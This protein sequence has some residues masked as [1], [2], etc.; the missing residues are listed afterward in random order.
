MMLG[1]R[2]DPLD[3]IVAM[4][5]GAPF[6]G[7]NRPYSFHRPTDVTWDPQGNIFVSD[8]YTDSRVVKYD[9]NGRFIKSAGARGNGVMQFSTPHGITADNQGNIYVADRGNRR[10]VVLDNDLNWKAAWENVGA[11]WGVCMSQS[12]PQYLY[13]SNP[14][15]TGRCPQGNHGRD[16]QDDA[17]RQDLGRFG[18]RRQG[19]R[20]VRERPHH[21]LPRPER[22]VHRGNQGWRVQKNTLSRARSP[23]ATRRHP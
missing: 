1:K 22:G 19:G 21:G 9:R 8:G 10:V 16:L 13:S 4:P 18:P 20:A 6:S 14:R 5:G 17:G 3:Q 2:P 12:S 11:P 23:P 15:S 7:A